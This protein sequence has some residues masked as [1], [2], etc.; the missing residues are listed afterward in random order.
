[1]CGGI[2]TRLRPLSYYIQKAMIP[3]GRREKPLL[4]YVVRLLAH[5][6]IKEIFLLADYKQ[7]QIINYFADGSRF[8]VNLTYLKDDPNTKGSLGALHNAYKKGLLKREENFLVYYGDILSNIN[9]EELVHL[10]TEK[11]ASA[12]LAL[13][14]KYPVPV[15]VAEVDQE[16]VV[17]FLEK[18]ELG[19]PV[20]IGMLALNGKVLDEQVNDGKKELDIM[21]DLIPHLIHKREPV[22]PYLTDAFWYDVGS[23]EKYEKLTDGTLEE[24][25]G[26]LFS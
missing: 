8:N 10:H 26:F 13:S 22:Y 17:E 11:Q 21:G 6:Q 4:E 1:M 2:G 9:L 18:P 15:G 24:K 20:S 16:R 25:L 3:V 23:L 7:E 5:Y 14:P 19:R 12:T